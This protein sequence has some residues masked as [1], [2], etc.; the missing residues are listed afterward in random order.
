MADNKIYG[1]PNMLKGEHILDRCNQSSK[2]PWRV[3]FDQSSRT[4]NVLTC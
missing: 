3:D 4:K 1:E 2:S